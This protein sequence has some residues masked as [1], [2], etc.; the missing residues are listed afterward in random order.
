MW[1]RSEAS[2]AQHLSQWPDVNKD[3]SA[4][5]SF[6][7]SQC[8][9]RADD[10]RAHQTFCKSISQDCPRP[11]WA[12]AAWLQEKRHLWCRRAGGFVRCAWSPGGQNS[13]PRPRGA[14]RAPGPRAWPRPLLRCAA[15]VS[16]GC[17]RHRPGP[18]QWP[19]RATA[20]VTAR[21]IAHTCPAMHTQKMIQMT[22][23]TPS[24][25][26]IYNL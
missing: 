22:V 9:A 23:S 20:N 25:F 19:A 14:L 5:P 24:T 13:R 11:A 7:F 18:S 15:A 8:P 2:V 16:P 26:T 10:L 21:C 12:T 1:D 6:T 4:I 17:C 3:A